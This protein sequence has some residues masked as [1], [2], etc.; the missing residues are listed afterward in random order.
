M[1]LFFSSGYNDDEENASNDKTDEREDY[2]K[3]YLEGIDYTEVPPKQLKVPPLEDHWII[4]IYK[5]FC[6]KLARPVFPPN[7][8]IIDNFLY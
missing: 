1:V 4:R 8:R 3:G 5:L 2:K 6:N 7:H